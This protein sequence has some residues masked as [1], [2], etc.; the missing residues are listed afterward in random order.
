MNNDSPANRIEL[1]L[2]EVEALLPARALGALEPDEAL[3]VERYLRD[4]ETLLVRTASLDQVAAHLNYAVEPV[5]P[6]AALRQQILANVA[7]TASPFAGTTHGDASAPGTGESA[8][9]PAV[10]RPTPPV[11][12][13]PVRR[14][15]PEPPRFDFFRRLYAW[16]TAAIVATA[17]MVLLAVG[18]FGLLDRTLSLAEQVQASEAQLA[19]LEEA[20]QALVQS[21]REFEQANSELAA[22]NEALV[23]E[24]NALQQGNSSLEQTVRQLRTELETRQRQLASLP[25]VQRV[26]P[27]AGTSDDVTASGS[28]LVENNNQALV[29]LD[30]LSTLPSDQTYQLW[31]LPGEEGAAPLPI[32]IFAADAATNVP[33]VVNVNLPAAPADDTNFGVSIEPA[34]GS[35]TP[36]DQIILLGT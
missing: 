4:H 23:S 35:S 36:G 9:R 3:A 28:F 33:T 13:A 22:A 27:L 26:V 11:P 2:S 30:G 15:T 16:R 29:V 8:G 12:R 6:S 25:N 7:A 18:A 5:A 32:D 34:G 14:S 19:E 10:A 1:T 21:S 31:Q 24:V 17:V 20:S